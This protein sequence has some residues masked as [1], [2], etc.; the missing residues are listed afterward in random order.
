M[1]LILGIF[2]ISNN[3]LWVGIPLVLLSINY[4]LISMKYE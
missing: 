3:N 4:K 1:T 2:L